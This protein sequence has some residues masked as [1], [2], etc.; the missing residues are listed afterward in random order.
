MPPADQLDPFAT[1]LLAETA[2][3]Q[4]LQDDLAKTFG[5]EAARAIT[6]SDELG[7]CSGSWGNDSPPKR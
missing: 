6:F 3:P 7:S 5:P 4:A 1:M 2:A